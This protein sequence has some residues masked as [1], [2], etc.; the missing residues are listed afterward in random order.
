MRC[1]KGRQFAGIA[2]VVTG[3]LAFIVMNE[4][5]RN[6]ERRRVAEARRT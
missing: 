2:I 3:L 4:R 1:V 6:A 5:A